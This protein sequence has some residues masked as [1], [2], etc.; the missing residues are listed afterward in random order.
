M[1]DFLTTQILMWQL[2]VILAFALVY[3]VIVCYIYH[4]QAKFY[5]D[6]WNNQCQSNSKLF[7]EL[8]RYKLGEDWQDEF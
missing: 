8:M 4:D 1:Q 6:L 2:L 7:S 5:K 3:V